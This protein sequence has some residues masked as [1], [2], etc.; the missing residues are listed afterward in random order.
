[1]RYSTRFVLVMAGCVIGGVILVSPASAGTH[2]VHP[3]ESIQAAVD[4]ASEGDTV[5]VRPGTYR[6]RVTIHKNGLTLRAQG[7]VTLEP[8]DDDAFSECYLT[9]LDTGICVAPAASEPGSYARRVRDVTITG[10][11]VVG[12]AGNGVFGYYTRNF[13]VSHVVAV[14]N[15]AYGVASFEGVGTT[16]THNAVSGSH[17]AGIYIGDSPD[18]EALV[19]HNRSWDNALGILVR[20]S[21]NAIVS[22]NDVWDNCLGV[23]LL[24]DGQAGG[25]GHIAVLDNRVIGNN[26]VCTQFAEVGF[27]P[28]LGGGGIV[29]AGSQSNAIF[30]NVV[31]G[32]Q[33]DTLFSGGIVLIQ[34]TLASEDSSFDRSIN[35]FVILNRSRG[36]APA[37]IVNDEASTPN[38]IVANRC[39][40][41]RPAGLCDF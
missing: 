40:I 35:N 27:L 7:N 25:S 12:F 37:D 9:G 18:A 31:R 36:N 26:D 22:D 24:A 28:I 20:H 4:A 16:F 19:A 30:N 34:T 29:L 6:E 2:V 17:D 23:F 32:N 10:F 15:A 5:V 39:D 33:G 11:R 14:D 38:F 8:P 3:G 41:S 13:K 1:M 21:R